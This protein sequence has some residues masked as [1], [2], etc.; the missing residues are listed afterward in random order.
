VNASLL[1][2]NEGETNQMQQIV[3]YLLISYPS[4]CFERPYAHRQG[5]GLRF[6]AYGFLSCY[7]CCDAGESGGKMCAL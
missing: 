2:V 3:I 5:V 1:S 6:T 4:T 7:S